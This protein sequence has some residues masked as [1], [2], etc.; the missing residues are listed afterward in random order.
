VGEGANIAAVDVGVDLRPRPA[1]WHVA[2][3][4]EHRWRLVAADGAASVLLETDE[5][6]LPTAA[7]GVAWPLEDEDAG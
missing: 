6:G 3:T 2:H 7:D 4:A 1:T 5:D